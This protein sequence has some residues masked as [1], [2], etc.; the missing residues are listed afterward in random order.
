MRKEKTEKNFPCTFENY[1]SFPGVCI[2]KASSFFGVMVHS[3]VKFTFKELPP[4]L[5]GRFWFGLVRWGG[6][7]LSNSLQFWVVFFSLV[8][9]EFLSLSPLF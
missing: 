3:D 5:W 8:S 9:T 1:N 7:P 2:I 4:F 6:R